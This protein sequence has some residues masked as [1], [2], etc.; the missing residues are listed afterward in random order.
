MGEVIFYFGLCV[1]GH[2]LFF[3]AIDAAIQSPYFGDVPLKP[4]VGFLLF[5]VLISGAMIEFYSFIALI[6]HFAVA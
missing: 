1:L 6:Y 5:S 4:T 2:Y 3:A